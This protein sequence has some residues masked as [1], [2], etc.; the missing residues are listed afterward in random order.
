MHSLHTYG[1]GFH[2]AKYAGSSCSVVVDIWPLRKDDLG[3]HALSMSDHKVFGCE[4]EPDGQIYL[5]SFSRGSWED[6]FLNYATSVS[7]RRNA[8]VTIHARLS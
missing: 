6:K 8:V 4:L 2:V 7:L 1:G 5:R 3:P